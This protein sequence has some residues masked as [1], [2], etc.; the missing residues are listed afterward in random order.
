MRYLAMMPMLLLQI[1]NPVWNDKRGSN[2]LDGGAPYYDTYRT[3][4][5]KYM[6]VYRL[7]GVI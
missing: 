4:D 6:S 3:K 5:G 2:I 1:S 7:R